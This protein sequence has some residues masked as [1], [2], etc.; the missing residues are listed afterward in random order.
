A[1]SEAER[2]GRRRCRQEVVPPAPRRFPR[3]RAG[4]R[5]RTYARRV[6]RRRLR[7]EAT[8]NHRSQAPQTIGRSELMMISIVAL[9][10]AALAPAPASYVTGLSVVPVA[11]RTEVVIELDAAVIASDYALNEPAR[12]VL[13]LSGVTGVKPAQHVIGR[14]G[15]R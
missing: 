2:R 15:V 12:L 13:D 10:L 14:G 4:R 1:G 11:D 7:R 6:L 3:Q 9:S 5:D 8:G